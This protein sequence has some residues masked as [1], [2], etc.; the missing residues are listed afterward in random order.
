MRVVITGVT[1]FLGRHIARALLAAGHEVHGIA[2]TTPSYPLPDG[3]QFIQ[4]AIGNR[5]LVG[6]LLEWAEALVH[7]AW[8][9][10]PASSQG[11]PVRELSANVLPT[12]AL[13]EELLKHPECRVLFVSTGG[14]LYPGT[15]HAC[16]ETDNAA[17]RSYY[18]AAKGAVELMLHALC[19]QAGHR[20]TVLRPSNVYG[21]G[22]P[23]LPGFG[24]IPALMR[25]ARDGIAFECWGNGTTTR[26]F[27]YIDDFTDIAQK[28]LYADLPAS[29]FQLLNAGSGTMTSLEELRALM[30]RVTGKEIAWHIRE[31]RVVDPTRVLLDSSRA[32]ELFGWWPKVGIEQG[33]RL[34]WESWRQPQ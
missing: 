5:A 32:R 9:G 3:T 22:Q 6:P 4:G 31:A 11:L 19:Q 33:L 28:A 8:E 16:T 25:C 14:A 34:T 17:P 12:A 2:R 1:G 23:A 18:G 15:G 29:G 20:A 26:D 10:T 21:P 13:M 24:V 30:A 7:L 27:L